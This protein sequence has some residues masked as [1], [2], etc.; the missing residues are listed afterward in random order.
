MSKTLNIEQF[1]NSIL[2]TLPADGLA[3]REE[4]KDN[5]RTAVESSLARMNLVSREEFD[6]QSALL[7]RTRIKLAELEQQ[8]EQLRQAASQDV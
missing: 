6:A 7:Q 8:L 3:I 5:L 2:R 4:V 1:L